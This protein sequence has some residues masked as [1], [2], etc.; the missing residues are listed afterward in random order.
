[1]NTIEM[2]GRDATSAGP[3]V[4][5]RVSMGLIGLLALQAWVWTASALPKVTS[6]TFL[7]GFARFVAT[8]VPTRPA[9]YGRLVTHLVGAAPSL[10]AW[11]AMATETGLALTFTVTTVV[12]LARRG[13]VP[14]RLLLAAAAASL[15]GAGFTLNLALLVGDPAPWKLGDPF[16]SGVALEY[17]LVGIGLATA[18][19]AIG[20]LWRPARQH[21]LAATAHRN[22]DPHVSGRPAVAPAAVRRTADRSRAS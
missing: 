3:S 5:R 20:T 16:D 15:V 1:M 19:A 21:L 17:L 14:R 13:A 18:A 9:L 2:R 10:F 6:S 7:S 8:P 12:V 11:G 4:A 22:T